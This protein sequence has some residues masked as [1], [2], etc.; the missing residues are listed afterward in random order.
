MCDLLERER[1]IGVDSITEAVEKVCQFFRQVKVVIVNIEFL[2]DLHAKQ[3]LPKICRRLYIDMPAIIC[4]YGKDK[5]ALKND[6]EKRDARYKMIDF[7]P[8]DPEFPERYIKAIKDVYPDLVFDIKRAKE[9]WL[10]KPGEEVQRLIDPHTWL[11]EQGFVEI[12]DKIKLGERHPGLQEVTSA[13]EE[14]LNKEFA[15]AQEAGAD[16][17]QLYLEMKGKYEELSV[18]VKELVEFVKTLKV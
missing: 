14:I 8:N 3:L 13:I 12:V 5:V 2:P 11:E 16:Y 4:Y 7:I 9:S 18:Y 6:L 17:K 15:V 1:V 10:R